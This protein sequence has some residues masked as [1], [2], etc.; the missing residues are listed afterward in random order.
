[1]NT[2]ITCPNCHF[3]F[4]VDEVLAQTAEKRVRQELAAEHEAAL[5]QAQKD[6]A[7]RLDE[8][9][10]KL[11]ASLR[12][13]LQAEYEASQADLA[14]KLKNADI[15]LKSRDQTLEKLRAENLDFLREKEKW[16]QEKQNLALENQKQLAAEREKLT[17][18]IS[19]KVEQEHQL[20]LAEKDKK[21]AD[22]MAEMS[23]LRRK[24]EQ[25]SQQSQG[26]VLELALEAQLRESFPD[27]AIEPIGKGVNGADV[28]QRVFNTKGVECGKIIWECKR[29]KNWTE[30]WIGKLKEDQRQEK[31]ELAVLTTTQMPKTVTK[32]FAFYQGIWVCKPE[33]ATFVATLLRFNLVRIG[34]V[35][36]SQASKD[37]KVEALYRYLTGPEFSQKIESQ[38][39]TIGA[40]R[41]Q[42]EKEKTFWTRHFAEREK[43]IEALQGSVVSLY[44][45]LQGITQ[46]A[47]PAVKSLE[48][49]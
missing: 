29:T 37:E 8:Q 21:L 26:E 24:L 48:G 18:Q 6:F 17:A 15:K 46:G 14:E 3:E 5:A 38:Y 36:D 23:V 1:M 31:A 34:F 12:E 40:L 13:S 41:T 9:K 42:L 2:K 43:Q 39:E 32:D 45:G 30:S 7:A 4:A 44:G 28:R 16:A 11:S 25:G 27:D 20:Q 47:L 33:L 19:Q 35:L 49:D 10:K 22:A